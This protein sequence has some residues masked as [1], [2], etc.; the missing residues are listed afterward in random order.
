MK[1][2]KTDNVKKLCYSVLAACAVSISMFTTIG[3]ND[4]E[5][6][7]EQKEKEK[8]YI[9]Q[10][11]QDNEFVGKI[12]PITEEQ[13]YAQ[14]STTD[15]SKNEFVL[16]DD[17]G[18]YMQIVRKGEGPTFVE[19]AKERADS[20]V[21]RPLLCKFLEYNIEQGDTTAINWYLTSIEDK[22]MCTYSHYSRSYTAWYTYGV[23]YTTYKSSTVPKGWLKPL[24]FIRLTK[25]DGEGAMVRLIVPH[26][27]GTSNASGQVLPC[28]YQITYQIPPNY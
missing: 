8:R 16:F 20:T 11:L 7:A 6:Y 9:A 10:F 1:K 12:N 27:S 14:D 3:C 26:T 2:R 17:D 23:M 24:D 5:T 25:K 15:V 13:F 18:I 28:Y 21:T 22:M 19:L 4:G